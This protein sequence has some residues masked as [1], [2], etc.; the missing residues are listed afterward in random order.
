[1]KLV[2]NGEQVNCGDGL[3]VNKLLVEQ[4]VKMPDMVSVELNGKILKRNEF[5]T[6]ALKEGDKLEFL[7]FMGGGERKD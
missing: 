7:Y 6:T 3:T 5:E 4:N 1:M 2:V